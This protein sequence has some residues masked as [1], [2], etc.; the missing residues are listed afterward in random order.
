MKNATKFLQANKAVL[1]D[2]QKQ[3][4]P[5]VKTFLQTEDSNRILEVDK[6]V[7]QD[8]LNN[9]KSKDKQ[10]KACKAA[11]MDPKEIEIINKERKIIKK[12][13]QVT[14]DQDGNNLILVTKD[15]DKNTIETTPAKGED[16]DFF[17]SQKKSSS[18]TSTLLSKL[19]KSTTVTTREITRGH[20]CWNQEKGNPLLVRRL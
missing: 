3:P 4:A 20:C 1:K 6:N 16:E 2:K 13:V 15:I 9:Q 18:N 14:Q 12:S 19:A 10:L 11:S 7:M 8:L 5:E 17:E